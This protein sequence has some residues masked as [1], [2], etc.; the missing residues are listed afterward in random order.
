MA[1]VD[2]TSDA[3]DAVEDGEVVLVDFWAALVRGSPRSKDSKEGVI[4]PACPT[5]R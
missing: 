1:T 2:V 3:F 4:S 5:P